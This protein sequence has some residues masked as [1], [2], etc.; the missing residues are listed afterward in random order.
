MFDNDYI[1]ADV[2]HCIIFWQLSQN[3]E[4]KRAF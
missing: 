3:L 1:T 4:E 2:V